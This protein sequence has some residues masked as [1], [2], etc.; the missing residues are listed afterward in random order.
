MLLKQPG[1]TAVAVLT[2]ALG[3]G[4][5]AAV[6]SLI[7]GVLLT[8][9]PLIKTMHNVAAVRSGYAMDRVLTM[10]VT[11]VQGDWSDFHQRAL[12]RVSRRPGVERAAFAWG[13]PSSCERRGIR[14]RSSARSVRNWAPSIPRSRSSV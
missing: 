3:I 9:P 12:E 13:T 6:F 10:T 8:R 4:A 11:A 2:L 7:D 5:T 14:E 1:F